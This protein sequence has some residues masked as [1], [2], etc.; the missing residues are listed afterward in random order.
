V[1]LRAGPPAGL[2][3]LRWRGPG[4]CSLAG[5]VVEHHL[6]EFIRRRAEVVHQGLKIGSSLL[7][8]VFGTG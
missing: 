1:P 2:Y 3:A 4:Y 7:R 6:P 5:V 8:A